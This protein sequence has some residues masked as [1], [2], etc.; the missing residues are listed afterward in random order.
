MWVFPSKR[1][2][3]REGNSENLKH[4]NGNHDNSDKRGV[5]R[6]IGAPFLQY[7]LSKCIIYTIHDRQIFYIFNDE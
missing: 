2:E 6:K 3:L 5:E 4:G 1:G 7:S